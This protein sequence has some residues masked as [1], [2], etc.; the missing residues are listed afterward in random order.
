MAPA[1]RDALSYS[2][3]LG[4]LYYRSAKRM[5][6]SF[7]SATICFDSYCKPYPEWA[8]TLY[9]ISTKYDIHTK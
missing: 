7:Y 6:I 5:L 2:F 8:Y 1:R 3:D 9:R 4:S